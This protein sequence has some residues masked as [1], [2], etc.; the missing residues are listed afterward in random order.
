MK[1]K[2]IVSIAA[3]AI[4]LGGLM[5][6]AEVAQTSESVNVLITREAL[7]ETEA[8]KTL[9]ALV[10]DVGT[11]VAA[12]NEEAGEVKVMVNTNVNVS[13]TT[14]VPTGSALTA[15]YTPN[16]TNVFT[17]ADAE[18]HASSYLLRVSV[19]F[20]GTTNDWIRVPTE[21]QPD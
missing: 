15:L 14:V 20:G 13:L 19:N 21:V 16:A 1:K 10:A 4:T 9:N 2:L 18:S 11:I 17:T 12:F 7:L 3:F 6:T 5:V 8:V